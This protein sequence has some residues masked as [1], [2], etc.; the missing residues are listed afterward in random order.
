MPDAR[1]TLGLPHLRP[2]AK[3]R[4]ISQSAAELALPA[5]ESRLAERI[6]SDEDVQ[7]VLA[8]E[9]TPIALPQDFVFQRPPACGGAT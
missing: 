6:V 9:L 3:C 2:S 5:Y 4:G 1:V 7:R 8:V